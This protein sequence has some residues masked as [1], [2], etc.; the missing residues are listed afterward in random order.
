[1]EPRAGGGACFQVLLPD[2]PES[3][4]LAAPMSKEPLTPR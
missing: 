1:V 2:G 3:V 4:P